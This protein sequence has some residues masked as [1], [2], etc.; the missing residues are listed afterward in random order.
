MSTAPHRE[1]RVNLRRMATALSFHPWNNSPAEW[2]R[3]G[4][5]VERLGASAP[6]AAHKALAWHAVRS[7]ALSNRIGG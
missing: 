3:L 6:M 1:T 5:A 2:Q 4:D 7:V